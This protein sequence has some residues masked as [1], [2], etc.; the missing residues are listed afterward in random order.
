MREFS[1]SQLGSQTTA[2]EVPDEKRYLKKTRTSKKRYQYNSN[3]SLLRKETLDP[4]LKDDLKLSAS[5][6]VEP[7]DVKRIESLSSFQ[8]HGESSEQRLRSVAD[9]Q[10]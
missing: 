1:V 5:S 8:L 7:I 3:A 9:Y 4:L 10:D 6:I 2:A